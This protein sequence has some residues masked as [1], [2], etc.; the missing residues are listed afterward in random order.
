MDSSTSIRYRQAT[1]KVLGLYGSWVKGLKNFET[2]HMP[3]VDIVLAAVRG[4]LGGIFAQSIGVGV[5][6]RRVGVGVVSWAARLWFL[7]I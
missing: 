6:L 7:L 2:E 3:A 4:G 5:E 1:K